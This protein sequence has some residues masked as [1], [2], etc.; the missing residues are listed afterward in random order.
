MLKIIGG[1]VLAAV[2]TGGV[3]LASAAAWVATGGI[4]VCDIKTPDVSLKVPIPARL[5]EI[6]LLIAR[7]AIPEEQRREMREEVGAFRPMIETVL[8]SL[9][10]LPE[11][12]L[13]SVETDSESVYV[14]REGSTF[15][16]DVVADDADVRVTFPTRSFRRLAHGVGELLGDPIV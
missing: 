16:V 15:V 10:D 13:V 6:G 12:T 4:A 9:A 11:G 5:A 14:G 2:L 3:T 1:V 8:E 7:F